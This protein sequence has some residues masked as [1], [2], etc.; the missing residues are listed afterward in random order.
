MITATVESFAAN[1]DRLAA[2]FPLHYEKLAL[3]R[4]AVPLDPN[5]EAYNRLEAGGNL[6]L[7]V[8][9]DR[10][11]IVGYWSAVIEPGLHYRTCLTAHMDM[12]NVLPGYENGVAP[13]ILMRAVEREYR[14][15]GV[16]RSFVGEKNHRPCGRLYTAFGYA[17]VETHYSKLIEG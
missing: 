6:M 3:D 5:Y 15:R 8:L 7:V 14:R 2:L 1:R 16:G 11:R 9:R 12:W 17:P 13:M 10:G 4:G